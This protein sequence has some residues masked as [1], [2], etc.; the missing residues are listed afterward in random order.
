MGIVGQRTHN[1]TVESCKV[2]PS[3]GRMISCTADATHFSNCTGKIELSHC[4]FE[5]QMDDADQYTWNICTNCTSDSS[6]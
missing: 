4:I 6:Q 5:N 1:V 2:T 3:N